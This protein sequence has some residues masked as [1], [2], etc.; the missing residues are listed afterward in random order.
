MSP[1]PALPP[2]APHSP[3]P[4]PLL[5]RRDHFD[6]LDT[7]SVNAARSMT[8]HLPADSSRRQSLTSTYR[9][10]AL[11]LL[12][13]GE[14]GEAA[15]VAVTGGPC[16]SSTAGGQPPAASAA[17]PPLMANWVSAAPV[18]VAGRG[19]S[20]E[21]KEGGP[22]GGISLSLHNVTT[23][24]GSGFTD[25]AAAADGGTPSSVAMLS[26]PAEAAAGA[27]W[28][29][30]GGGEDGEVAALPRDG[31][32][33]AALLTPELR[34]HASPLPARAGKGHN[35]FGQTASWRWLRPTHVCC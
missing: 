17:G 18:A 11:S 14:A 15:V 20:R 13:A 19:A 32:Y 3:L 5:L 23:T 1:S 27:A 2:P 28:H 31:L 16:A 9:K 7:V 22:G 25:E 26:R 12:Q 6:S 35:H 4:P 29:V 21:E 10:M 24:R 34:E 30:G 8:Q 33:A